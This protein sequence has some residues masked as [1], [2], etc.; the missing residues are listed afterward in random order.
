M[1][2]R[3][4]HIP[5]PGETVMGSSFMTIQGGKGANQ[6]VAAVRAGAEVTFIAC[7]ADDAFGKQ[8]VDAYRL[9]GIDVSVIK[10]LAGG[11]SGIALINVD[12]VG[13]NSISVAPG[14]N[15]YLYPAD[16]S[17]RKESFSDADLV[18]AQLEVPMETVVAAAQMA[19]ANGIPFILNPAPG[20]VLPEI[21]YELVTVLIP[22]QTEAAALT[23][24]KK[25]DGGNVQS[26]AT[27]L[28]LRG[29]KNVIVTM[30]SKGVFLKNRNYEGFIPG[31]R[32]KAVDTTAAGDVFNGAFACA[33][34]KG[35]P[36]NDAIDFAQRAAAIS[37][38][39]IGAQPSAPVYDEIINYGF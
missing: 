15:G 7:V 20:A 35:I 6:A 23:G 13:E 39:R 38:T 19:Q 14:A 27:A 33:I 12:K 11:H 8:S 36:V 24:I 10:V 17:A 4:P 3:V 5:A 28:Y 26:L 18:L 16:I 21:L 30:G 1:V 2:V 34:A 32:V 25:Q 31:Y 22:N 37:V 29:I 9:E